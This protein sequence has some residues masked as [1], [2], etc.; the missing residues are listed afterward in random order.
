MTG[1]IEGSIGW[2]D[3][4]GGAMEKTVDD[5]LLLDELRAQIV[6][7]EQVEV[8][9]AELQKIRTELFDASEA[10]CRGIESSREVAEKWEWFFEQSLD[11]LCTAG[12]DGYFKRVNGAF[13]RAL[14]YT[15]EELLAKS[16]LTFIHPDDVER[17]ALELRKLG[18]GCDSV[19]FENRYRHK[20]GSWRWLSWTCPASPP[21]AKYLYAIARDVTDAKRSEAEVLFRAQHDSLT[22][23]SNRAM[24]DQLLDHAV[25]RARRDEARE[26]GLF[27][28]DVDDFKRVN[29]T[30]GH[31]AGDNVLKEIAVRLRNGQRT[32][33][34]AFRLG[35]DEFAMIIE[36]TAPIASER[37]G[38]KIAKRLHAPIRLGTAE[39]DVR[40][41]IGFSAFP[42]YAS[43]PRSLV[44]RADAAMYE[45][46]A[47]RKTAC[48]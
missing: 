7:L 36:G 22:G 8:Q 23:L 14:G 42:R 32:T 16:F 21:G 17:T 44:E 41:S 43:D 35:G 12:L 19:R 20:D 34:L 30:F 13:S 48:G 18:D 15:R 1:A 5:R 3:D 39:L 4:Q 37:I 45:E 47:R 26:V 9:I 6:R 38:R 29:D 27:L 25:A 11:I 24:F 46:K 28:F 40:C 10:L 31:S 2:G 33:D